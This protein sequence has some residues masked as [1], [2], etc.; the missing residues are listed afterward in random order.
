MLQA[1][2]ALWAGGSVLQR[3]ISKDAHPF[4]TGAVQQLAAGVAFAPFALGA[5]LHHPVVFASRPTWALAYLI[6]FGAIVGYSSYIYALTHLPV[7]MVSIYNYVNPVVAVFL[8][9]VFYREPF[10]YRES[11]GMAIIFIGVAL[12]KRFASRNKNY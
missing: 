4:L 12:V 7:S 10:G 1:G 3:R 5:H 6:L 11:A 2:S 9:W 8:G